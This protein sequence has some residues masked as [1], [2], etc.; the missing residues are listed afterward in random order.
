MR[1]ILLGQL[2]Q[3]PLLTP[4]TLSLQAQTVKLAASGEQ[5]RVAGAVVSAVDGV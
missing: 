5:C 4:Q 1:G 3:L 2:C